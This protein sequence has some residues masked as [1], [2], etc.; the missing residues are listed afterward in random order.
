MSKFRHQ[1]HSLNGLDEITKPLSKL[2][3]HINDNGF[4]KASL[5]YR[6]YEASWFRD[7]SMIAIG[8]CK[9]AE[10]LRSS[11]DPRYLESETAAGNII[12]FLWGSLDKFHSNIERAISADTASD[13]FRCLENHVPA[14]I[15]EDGGYF[16]C[17][18][19]GMPYSD[20]KED[21]KYIRLRQYDS[22]PLTIM[23]TE[24]IMDTIGENAFD[25]ST[26]RNI[27][28]NLGNLTAYM[29]KVYRTASAN[30]WEL[31][32]NE[33]HSYTVAS[34]SK[35]IR[36]AMFIA[37]RLGIDLS[38]LGDINERVC[39][40]D[41]FIKETF[42]RDD[43]LFKSAT[44]TGGTSVV[45][46]PIRQVDASAIFV[47]TLFKPQIGK[48]VEKATIER[49]EADL[50]NGNVLPIRYLDDTYFSGG[51]WPLLGL[52]FAKYYAERGDTESAYKI[53]RYVKEQYLDITGDG[54]IP[55]QELVN[56]AHPN[57]DLDNWFKKNGNKVIGELGWAAA[58]YLMAVVAY[59]KAVK[60]TVG[61]EALA[62]VVREK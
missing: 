54:T 10:F 9:V 7:S 46:E 29:L 42:V 20:A 27:R 35:G 1:K 44:S 47:F 12:K 39:E 5:A 57:E 50:F 8:L 22:V 21:N 3:S 62:A 4:T 23:A 32:D 51:R 11:Q 38:S 26:K 25:T 34:I 18:Q 30:A 13:R 56:P 17:M 43:I 33:V 19:E 41:R 59:D 37:E 52:E 24:M 2:L 15:G 16:S 61:K 36:S 31:D 14:R 53:I 49:L 6:W 28:S 40:I 60:D 45:T 58:E 48:N 55:E